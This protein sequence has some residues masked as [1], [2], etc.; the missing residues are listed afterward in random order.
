VATKACGCCCPTG[1]GHVPLPRVAVG[2]PR[3]VGPAVGTNGGGGLARRTTTA[4]P[5]LLFLPLLPPQLSLLR[6]LLLFL[7]R[8]PPVLPFLPLG[9][10]D[11]VED[12]GLTAGDAAL[13]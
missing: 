9:G 3:F 6:F 5:L 13:V 1:T 4:S 12:G 10:R 2:R 8:L 7:F 11:D